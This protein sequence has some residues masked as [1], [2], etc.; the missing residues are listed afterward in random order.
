MIIF[1]SMAKGLFVTCSAMMFIKS[2]NIHQKENK[3]IFYKIIYGQLVFNFTTHLQKMWKLL[4]A[5]AI[6]KMLQTSECT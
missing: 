4:A 5:L 3:H 2:K 1:V 6:V